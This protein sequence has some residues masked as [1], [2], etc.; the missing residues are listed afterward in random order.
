VAQTLDEGDHQVARVTRQNFKI[1]SWVDACVAYS[2]GFDL[3]G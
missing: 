2:V 1:C 3:E